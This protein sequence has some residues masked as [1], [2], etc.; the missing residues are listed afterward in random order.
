MWPARLSVVVVAVLYFTLPDRLAIGPQWLPPL[1]ELALLGTLS[2]MAPIRLR[3]FSTT[4]RWLSVALLGLI[5]VTNT[6]SLVLLI[7]A[8]LHHGVAL[9]G[10]PMSGSLL[11]QGAS[12]IWATNVLVTALLYWELDRGGPARRHIHADRYPDFLF[13]QMVA[14]ACAPVHWMPA[15]VDY[16]FVSFTNASAFSPT[17]TLPLTGRIKAIMLVQA[18][19]SLL[20]VA[21]VAARAVNIL[22]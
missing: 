19:T 16:L 10:M 13:P 11:L 12:Q 8:L 6:A 17:D 7:Y 21:L 1:V 20:T 2:V 4:Q 22:S 3:T 9:H 14:P 15:F 5:V 18:L